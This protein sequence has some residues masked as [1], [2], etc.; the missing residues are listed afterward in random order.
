MGSDCFAD[1][2]TLHGNQRA[3]T[4]Y[5]TLANEFTV[6]KNHTVGKRINFRDG[7]AIILCQAL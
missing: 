7:I 3:V 2:D 6:E 1:L 5:L 4:V